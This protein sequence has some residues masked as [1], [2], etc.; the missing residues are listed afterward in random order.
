MTLSHK[1]CFDTSGQDFKKD[2][3]RYRCYRHYNT[4]EHWLGAY[5]TCVQCTTLYVS[6]ITCPVP[7]EYVCE[8]S[9]TLTRGFRRRRQS[10][11]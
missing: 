7:R 11:C 6:I 3:I 8:R 10:L 1:T 5:S 2:P 4:P 9:L